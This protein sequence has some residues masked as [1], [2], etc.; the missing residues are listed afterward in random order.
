MYL[1]RD[2]EHVLLTAIDWRGLHVN[3]VGA[4]VT[5]C[6]PVFGYAHPICSCAW[7]TPLPSPMVVVPFALRL[8]LTCGAP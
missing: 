8:C 7:Y 6:E 3:D 2:E 5:L 1:T 4:C